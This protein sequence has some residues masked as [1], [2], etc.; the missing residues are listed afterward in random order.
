MDEQMKLSGHTLL[1]PAAWAFALLGL[2]TIAGC[3]GSGGL[4]GPEERRVLHLSEVSST[5]DMAPG[6]SCSDIS[7]LVRSDVAERPLWTATTS[8][9]VTVFQLSDQQKLSDHSW[10]FTFKPV[11]GLPPGTY[12]GTISIDPVNLF[13]FKYFDL[14]ETMPYKVTVAPLKGKLSSLAAMP[15]AGDWEGTNG[16]AAHTGLVPVSVNA[17][18]FTRRWTWE[19]LPPNERSFRFSAP[20]TANGLVYFSLEQSEQDGQNKSKLIYT[21]TL[22]ALSEADSST[23]WRTPHLLD[24]GLSAPG[25][26]GARL[27]MADLATVYTVDAVSGVK[28]AMVQQPSTYGTLTATSPL[29]APTMAGGNVYVGGNN[30]V[31][32]ADATTAINRWSTSLGLSKFNNVDEWTPAVG[33]STVY[34]N[35]AGTLN[36]FNHVDGTLQWS[37]AVPGQVLGGLNK[38]SLRQAP[39]LVDESTLLLLN[40]RSLAG[41]SVDNSLSLVDVN[42]RQL[43]WTVNGRYTTQP[44][45]ALGVA[46]VGNQATS[47]IEARSLATG[48][49]LWS[50]PLP[51]VKDEYFAG[52]LILTNNVLFVAGGKQTYAIDLASHKAVWTFRM[53]GRL[54]LSRNGVLYIRNVSDNG[55]G[56]ARLTAIN[57]Q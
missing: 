45:A 17:A 35:T 32:S 16:N 8:N 23:Q 3:G 34:G 6:E 14:P 7:V 41:Q 15:G 38:S 12:T 53:G 29:T 31:I 20:V 28:L 26:S 40:Q 10:R 22:T 48:E 24:M 33:A 42:S 9:G 39:V 11:P 4:V 5:C 44:V 18:G 25:V 30:D 37:V 47:S 56:T 21:N 46:Y 19:Y 50:W 1:R 13:A 57:L 27:A 2:A 55:Y 51:D 36:A 52:D 54:A 49:V 43:R